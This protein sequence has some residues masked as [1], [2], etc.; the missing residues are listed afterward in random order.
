[1]QA[2]VAFGEIMLRLTPPDLLR[3]IQTQSYN[4]TFGGAEANVAIALARFGHRAEYVTRLPAH[5]LGE[6]VLMYL[7]QYGVGVGHVARGGD[8]LGVYFVEQGAAQRGGKVIYDRARS[9][10]AELQPGMIDWRAVFTAANA[11][12]F[13][14]TGITPALTESSADTCREAI[15]VARELG[16]TI[17]CDLNYRHALWK[18]GKTSADVMPDLV[19]Q[20]D[21]VVGNTETV[22]TMFGL[23][24]RDPAADLIDQN[25]DV[26]EQVAERCPQLK[27]IAFTTRASHSASHNTWS[28]VLWQ[29][30]QFYTGASY[31]LTPIVDRVGAGDAFTAGLIYGLR[32]HPE[33]PEYALNFATA[34]GCLKHTIPG[35]ALLVSVDE[36]EQL[37]SGDSSGKIRR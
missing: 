32:Q 18:W 4:V 20:S 22:H 21:V 24:P 9:S 33:N 26:A 3:L 2:I 8:R 28:A 15:S 35:D 27:T 37:M 7:R 17:S 23:K 30:G 6:A 11:D 34:A 36:V 16:L 19:A 12:W 31:D 14:W 13:H 10:A 1:M 5:D 25:R 29:R